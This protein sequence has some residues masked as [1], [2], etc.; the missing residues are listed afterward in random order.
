MLWAPRHMVRL[1]WIYIWEFVPISVIVYLTSLDC[2]IKWSIQLKI[3]VCRCTMIF[4]WIA[5][6]EQQELLILED[7]F[8]IERSTLLSLPSPSLLLGLPHI[9]QLCPLSFPHDSF[10]DPDWLTNHWVI[11]CAYCIF[12]G[13][14]NCIIPQNG[15][16]WTFLCLQ[17]HTVFFRNFTVQSSPPGGWGY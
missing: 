5:G 3:S 14:S 2:S 6:W 13:W 10:L 15:T 17:N 16:V 7:I 1:H 11:T 4:I 8:N 9:I 12:C